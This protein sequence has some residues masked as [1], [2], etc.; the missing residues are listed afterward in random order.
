MAEDCQA[1][2]VHIRV[3]PTTLMPSMVGVHPPACVLSAHIR[4]R[5]LV[6]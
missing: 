6:C 3:P 5:S 2:D 1:E 4:T